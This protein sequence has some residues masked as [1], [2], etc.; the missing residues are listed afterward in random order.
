MTTTIEISEKF[1]LRDPDT[2][3]AIEMENI[4][5]TS[6]LILTLFTAAGTEDEKILYVSGSDL[7]ALATWIY[8]I[9]GI[10]EQYG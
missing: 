10:G 8:K 7:H 4:D 9:T 3:N 2:G 6:G 1:R 5:G